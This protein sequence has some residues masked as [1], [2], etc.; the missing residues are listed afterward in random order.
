MN[1]KLV[2]YFI[3]N[4][5][6]DYNI[7]PKKVK[8]PSPKV[9]LEEPGFTVTP[10][11][12]SEIKEQIESALSNMNASFQTSFDTNSIEIKEN[13]KN[14]CLIYTYKSSSLTI[15]IFQ[16]N[17]VE[18][19]VDAIVNAANSSLQIQGKKFKSKKTVSLNLN[20]VFF[21]IFRNEWSKWRY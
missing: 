18:Q 5:A 17:L 8:T 14:K 6:T 21:F 3:E 16:G 19:Q 15:A 4:L 2:D 13:T 10:A 12:K 1:K 7:N 20:S 9:K 11:K